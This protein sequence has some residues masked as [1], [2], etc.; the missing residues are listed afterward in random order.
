M[1]TDHLSPENRSR[2]MSR[3]RGSNTKPELRV[4][5]LLHRHGYRFRIHRRDLPGVPDIVLPKYNTVIFVHGCFWHGHVDC[6][7]ATIPRTR[8]DFWRRKIATNRARDIGVERLLDSQGYAVLILWECQL[9]DEEVL[10]KRVRQ[11]TAEGLSK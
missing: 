11:A 8:T 7:R 1:R 9:N 3:I 5:R 6:K 4:R 2:N 10:L